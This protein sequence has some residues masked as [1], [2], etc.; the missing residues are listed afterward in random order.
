MTKMEWTKLLSEKRFKETSSPREPFRTEFDKDYER[1]VGSSA[2]RRLQDKTQV[3][4]LQQDDVTR[5]R[6]THSL[7]VSSMARS[8]GKRIGYQLVENNEINESQAEKLSTILAVCGLIHDLGNPPF[9]HY[10]E[11]VIKNWFVEHTKNTGIFNFYSKNPLIEDYKNFDGNAQTIRILT[12]LQFHKNPYGMNFTFGT[13]AAL[14]KYPYKPQNDSKA[15]IGYFYSEEP[16]INEILQETGMKDSNSEKI[17]RNPIT[18]LLEAADDI[19]YLFADLEDAI[20]KGEVSFREIKKILFSEVSSK[21]GDLIKFEDLKKK[22]AKIQKNNRDNYISIN[23]RDFIEMREL[24]IFCQGIFIR[25]IHEEFFRNYEKI[26]CGEYVDKK[27]KFKELCKCNSLITMRNIIWKLCREYAYSNNEVLSLELKGKTVINTLLDNFMKIINDNNKYKDS[28]S[29][30]G[31]H[32]KLISENYK[33]IQNIE[34]QNNEW[35]FSN[36][37][38]NGYDKTQR[39][40]MI[41]DY[42]AGMTD[43]YALDLYKKLNGIY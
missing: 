17:R 41:V 32:F 1:I 23:E 21:K 15:K 19:C 33:H 26:M 4:P 31:K 30:E 24:K 29:E 6:L 18:Y 3:F 43:T 25:E 20:K 13:L 28:R 27:G 40:Q 22:L 42:I 38:E 16:L 7:E 39:I 12:R 11:D 14:L 36:N 8:L 9:G 5:T 35:K 2:L 37:I 34:N 10:G